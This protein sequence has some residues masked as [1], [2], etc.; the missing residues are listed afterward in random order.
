MG[1]VGVIAHLVKFPLNLECFY[2][3]FTV[4][5]CGDHLCIYIFLRCSNFTHKIFRLENVGCPVIPRPR[6]LVGCL[7]GPPFYEANIL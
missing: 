6:S 5:K 1:P 4:H 2:Q 7:P 3:A